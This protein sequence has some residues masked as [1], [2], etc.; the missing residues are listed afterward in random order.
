MF[1]K[2]FDHMTITV[3]ACTPHGGAPVRPG[4]GPHHLRVHVYAVNRS[5]DRA[6]AGLEADQD[7]TVNLLSNENQYFV[8]LL[9]NSDLAPD[10]APVRT[11]GE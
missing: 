4:L 8:L 5:I 7:H 2:S 6:L 3:D 10:L 1:S 11:T 9:S